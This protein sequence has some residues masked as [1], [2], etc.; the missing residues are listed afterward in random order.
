M[1]V[2]NCNIDF[3]KLNTIG[4]YYTILYIVLF[5]TVSANYYASSSLL[6]PRIPQRNRTN[7]RSWSVME[8]DIVGNIVQLAG[9]EIGNGRGLLG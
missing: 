4:S 2:S 6:I 8:R 1:H 3:Y 7:A 9:R 5:P